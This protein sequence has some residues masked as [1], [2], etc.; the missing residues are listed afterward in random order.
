MKLNKQSYEISVRK[1]LSFFRLI[2][3]S[4]NNINFFLYRAYPVFNKGQ[5]SDERKYIDTRQKMRELILQGGEE[6]NLEEE[7]WNN[8]ADID[9]SNISV[10][11]S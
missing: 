5:V 8:K 11:W 9:V 4:L 7:N 6:L 1:P 3:D 2:S 10:I